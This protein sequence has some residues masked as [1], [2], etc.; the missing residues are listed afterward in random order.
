MSDDLFRPSVEQTLRSPA[1]RRP[2][3]K[4]YSV[5]VGLFGGLWALA[6]VTLLNMHRLGMDAR[7]QLAR[8]LGSTVV[9]WL[10]VSAVG[11]ALLVLWGPDRLLVSRIRLGYRFAAMLLALLHMRWQI[12]GERHYELAHGDESYA[13]LWGPGIV[14]VIGGTLLQDLMFGT[15]AMPLA[16][17]LVDEP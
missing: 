12:P 16:W 4:D 8:V 17:T 11:I 9:T 15:V 14:A 3:D 6:A 2:W 7:A 10:V 5:L 1:R 13:S